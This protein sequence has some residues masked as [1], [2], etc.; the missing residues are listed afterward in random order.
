M[1][2]GQTISGRA[3]VAEQ[4]DTPV[5]GAILHVHM[6]WKVLRILIDLLPSCGYDD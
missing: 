4:L 3:L 6:V 5:L 1:R 2:D